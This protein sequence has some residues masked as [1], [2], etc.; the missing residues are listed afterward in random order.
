MPDFF[1]EM[2]LCLTVL[3][4]MKGLVFATTTKKAGV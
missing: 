2:E 4:L 1:D 3:R